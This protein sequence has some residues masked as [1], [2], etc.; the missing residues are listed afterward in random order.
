MESQTAPA[1][2]R[3]SMA[4]AH[5]CRAS[6]SSGFRGN[7]FTILVDTNQSTL[8]RVRWMVRVEMES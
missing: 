1:S 7:V 4:L 5:A 8:A 2:F 3:T 6:M